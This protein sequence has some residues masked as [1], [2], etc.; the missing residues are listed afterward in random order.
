MDFNT[1]LWKYVTWGTIEL[2]PLFL[3][4]ITSV[5]SKL[6]ISFSYLLFLPSGPRY[7]VDK[8][9]HCLFSL[10]ILIGLVQDAMSWII[11]IQTGFPTSNTLNATATS[12]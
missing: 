10:V 8:S 4:K 1:K 12:P 7:S 5:L 2:M 3:K 9:C 6:Q 11:E